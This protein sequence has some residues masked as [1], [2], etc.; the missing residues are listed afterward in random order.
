[1]FVIKSRFNTFEQSARKVAKYFLFIAITLTYLCLCYFFANS[2]FSIRYL[3]KANNSFDTILI[4]YS[5][6][7]AKKFEYVFQLKDHCM[8]P[9]D[10]I[11]RVIKS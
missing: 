8:R 9:N 2:T 7:Y 5:S 10:N 1:M 11:I 4:K 6:K 3:L